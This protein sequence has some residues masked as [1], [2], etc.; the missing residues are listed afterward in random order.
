MPGKKGF[1]RVGDAR[2]GP[3]QSYGSPLRVAFLALV[4]HAGGGDSLDEVL[5]GGEEDHYGG[6]IETIDMAMI[7]FQSKSVE[8]SIVILSPRATGYLAT[9]EM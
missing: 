8:M 4:L 3:P 2:K 6:R 1:D 9:L 7:R 5:L